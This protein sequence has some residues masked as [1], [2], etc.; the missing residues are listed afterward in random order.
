MRTSI[1]ILL[2]GLTLAVGAT[3]ADRELIVTGGDEVYVLDLANP[4]QPVK[5]FS[6]KA[7]GRPDVP[8]QLQPKFRTTDDGK[9][10][11]SGR[12]LITSSSGAVALVERPT[13]RTLFWARCSNAHSAELLPGGRIVVASSVHEN[14]G[15]R[16]VLFD[17][18]H[19]DQE[20]ASV[21]LYSAHGV[22]WDAR[23]QLLWAL[24]GN[25]LEAYT[26]AD[27]ETAAP[28]LKKTGSWALPSQ[29]GHELAPADSTNSRL[30]VSAINGAWL[31]DCQRKLFEPHP[32]FAAMPNLKSA[33]LHPETGEWA[34]T[35]ADSPEWWTAT[36]R[37][38]GPV[39]T[40]VRPGERLYKVR[41]A[42][43][44]SGPDR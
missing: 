12:I 20:L 25:Y 37:F 33:S 32:L 10:V 22:V 24:G 34:Y 28:S 27:W 14:G 6:W 9:A 41:W 30:V 42:A 23:R 21:P 2:A 17:V 31:F 16:L 3:A 35:L 4:A 11:G 8:A 13:G 36:I 1:Q 19:S 44:R 29:G 40:V 18:K 39:A 26:L 43:R 15:S 5:V 7:A 38:T